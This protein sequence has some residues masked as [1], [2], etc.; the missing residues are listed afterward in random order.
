VG[1]AGPA[2]RSARRV[3]RRGQL[4]D[5]FEVLLRV[6]DP[7]VEVDRVLE[8]ED[9]TLDRRRGSAGKGR[10]DDHEDAE[11]VLGGGGPARIVVGADR[12]REL[13][14][15]LHAQRAAL[16]A[17]LEARDPGV[18]PAEERDPTAEGQVVVDAEQPTGDTEGDELVDR[19]RGRRLPVG[20]GG[21]DVAAP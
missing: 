13:G 10:I 4:V 6:L 7:R 15:G 12:P 21:F 9:R 5:E 20:R 19:P 14:L 16:Q 2:Q 11:Q 18:R 1:P 17:G 8:L 3:G